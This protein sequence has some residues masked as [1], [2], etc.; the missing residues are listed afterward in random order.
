MGVLKELAISV[1]GSVLFLVLVWLFSRTARKATVLVA[2]RVLRLDIEETFRDASE[3]ATDLRE[4]L[5]RA[6]WVSVL[7]SRGND[8]QRWTFA[9]T[10]QAAEH[11]SKEVRVLLP[12]PEA[13]GGA[14]WISRREDEVKMFDHAFGNG[15][16][17]EQVRQNV[18]FLRGYMGGGRL[19]LR[20]YDLPHVARIVL[21]DRVAY[22][23]RYQSNRHGH[24]TPIKKYRRGDMCDYLSR[25]VDLAWD[26]A[27][28]ADP[29]R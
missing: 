16:L 19:E 12:D 11:G 22:L 27:R 15:L 10:L 8:L 14:D 25:T 20:F 24:S 7:T 4:E 29:D 21:T 23:T 17:R 13:T 5:E 9:S 18:T 26:N 28:P 6:R 1:A 2:S 3:A